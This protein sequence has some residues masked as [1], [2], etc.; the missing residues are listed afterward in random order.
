MLYVPSPKAVIVT[1]APVAGVCKRMCSKYGNER[2]PWPSLR[3]PF[4]T[5]VPLGQ[6][7]VYRVHPLPESVVDCVIDYGCLGKDTERM[8]IAAMLENVLRDAT[9]VPST[10]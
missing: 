2:L 5:L 8:Y 1:I 3:V 10:A 4:A 7:L 6:D 9:G